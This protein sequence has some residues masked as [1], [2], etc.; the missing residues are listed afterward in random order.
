MASATPGGVD[1]IAS[2]TSNLKPPSLPLL[3]GDIPLDLPEF[4]NSLLDLQ[5]DD[6]P[7]YDQPTI[8]G[9]ILDEHRNEQ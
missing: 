3:E 1:A 7:P 4:D 6:A 9:L 2:T 8:Q 5:S